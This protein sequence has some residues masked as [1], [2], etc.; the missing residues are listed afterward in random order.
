MQPHCSRGCVRGVQGTDGEVAAKAMILRSRFFKKKLAKSIPGIIGNR[1]RELV[2]NQQQTPK[3]Y[4]SAH[5]A[6]LLEQCCSKGVGRSISQKTA[7]LRPAAAA[8][9]GTSG[10]KAPVVGAISEDLA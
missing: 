9:P 1:A 5:S 8:T 7:V 6:S 3:P 10:P 4:I 2:T